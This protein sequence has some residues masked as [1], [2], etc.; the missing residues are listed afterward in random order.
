MA[1]LLTSPRCKVY[2][3]ILHPRLYHIDLAT[4]IHRTI[5]HHA[6][7]GGGETWTTCM[8]QACKRSGSDPLKFLQTCYDYTRSVRRPSRHW[9]KTAVR[10]R[11]R[12]LTVCSAPPPPR[13][14][15]PLTVPRVRALQQQ[16][17]Q[18]G[19]AGVPWPAWAECRT[20]VGR[21]DGYF[22]WGGK[23]ASENGTRALGSG[24]G[25]DDPLICAP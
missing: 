13:H 23:G 7:H 15:E 11:F 8:K 19:K 1:R 22:S 10:Q 6:L 24:K 4:S 5:P 3:E 12:R 20:Q 16:P 25:C 2:G 21:V 14:S 18:D 17:R 9:N